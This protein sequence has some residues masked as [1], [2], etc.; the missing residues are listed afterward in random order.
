MNNQEQSIVCYD[1]ALLGFTGLFSLQIGFFRRKRHKRMVAEEENVV[2]ED[3]NID[4]KVEQFVPDPFGDHSPPNVNQA[5]G[6]PFEDDLGPIVDQTIG[7]TIGGDNRANADHLQ[8]NADQ[9]TGISISDG[10]PVIDQIPS[11]LSGDEG[12]NVDLETEI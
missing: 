3:N 8:S 11:F 2:Q 6:T 9:E 10:E 12:L 1:S 5:V 7:L 4:D